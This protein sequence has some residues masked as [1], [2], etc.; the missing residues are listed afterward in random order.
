MDST[1]WGFSSS[2]ES[3]SDEDRPVSKIRTD[4]VFYQQYLRDDYSDDWPIELRGGHHTN[5]HRFANVQANSSILLDFNEQP[6]TSF[7]NLSRIA[8][9]DNSRVGSPDDIMPVEDFVLINEGGR[10][11]PVRVIS[12]T[13][14]LPARKSKTPESKVR[15]YSISLKIHLN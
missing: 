12:K 13:E 3:D 7:A 9:M 2:S 15:T 1:D 10:F 6:N 4:S 11:R 8:D 5:N 14:L